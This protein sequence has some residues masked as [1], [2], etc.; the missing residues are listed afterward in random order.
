L[1]SPDETEEQIE[2]RLALLQYTD[3]I[4][5]EYAASTSYLELFKG[6]NLRRTEIA[7][8]IYSCMNLDGY[9]L[10]ASGTYFF[11]RAGLNAADSFTLTC[12]NY[13]ISLIFSFGAWY[14]MSR[15]GR[16][17]LYIIGLAGTVLIQLAIGGLGIPEPSPTYAWATGGFCYLFNILFHLCNGPLTY[18]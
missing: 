9:T 8:M 15:F 13:A 12:T 6:T 14:C 11:Q 16:R 1:A 17:N 18:W 2:N 3:A 5:K 10:A 7:I 4:E